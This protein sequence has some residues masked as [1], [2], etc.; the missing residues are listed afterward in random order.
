MEH[1]WNHGFSIEQGALGKKMAPAQRTYGAE[2]H[3]T[4]KKRLYC[5]AKVSLAASWTF[6]HTL[7]GSVC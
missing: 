5:A 2:A 6:A 4:I 3:S 1:N 7:N